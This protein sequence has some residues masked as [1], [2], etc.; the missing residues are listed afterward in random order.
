MIEYKIYLINIITTLLDYKNK[1]ESFR[2]PLKLQSIDGKDKCTLEVKV[3]YDDESGKILLENGIPR[4]LRKYDYKEVDKDSSLY[5]KIIDYKN[6][7][8]KDYE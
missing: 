8:Y 2:Y 4:K 6:K 5:K 7:G 1:Y 3:L